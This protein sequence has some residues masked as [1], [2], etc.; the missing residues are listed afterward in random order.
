MKS[1][2]KLRCVSSSME[3]C[4]K[5][6]RAILLAFFI[7]A[8]VSAGDQRGQGDRDLSE[9]DYS[10]K[11]NLVVFYIPTCGSCRQALELLDRISGKYPDLVIVRKDTL[12]RGNRDLREMYDIF[13]GVPRERRGVV[14]AVFVGRAFLI[15]WPEIRDR[16]EGTLEGGEWRGSP[17]PFLGEIDRV[18]SARREAIRRFRSFGPFAVAFA[19]LTDGVNP[20]AFTLLTF[21]LIYLSATGRRGGMIFAVGLAFISAVFSTY[22]SIG[23]GLFR[24][25]RFIEG[26][27]WLAKAIY[28]IAG[29]LAFALAVLSLLDFFAV[30]RGN[31]ADM[32]LRLPDR[33]KDLARSLMRRQTRSRYVIP[34]AAITGLLVSAVEFACTGQVY[35]PTILYISDIPEYRFQGIL[36]LGLYNIM[37]VLPLFVVF[38]I[39]AG[40]NLTAQRLSASFARF[41]PAAKLAAAGLF[42]FLAVY[43]FVAAGLFY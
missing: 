35:L 10:S 7:L 14:P 42:L 11:G 28:W 3:R 27:R 13:Y 19:G 22:F 5:L 8:S 41:V 1:E 37:F 4:R 23:I 2:R 40:T 12:D 6:S 34:T 26:V 38:G 17:A 21:F 24:F 36:Y 15:G 16:L 33:L 20:C 18:S 39:V 32:R 9:E 31:A 30:R 43:M 25:L 29:S